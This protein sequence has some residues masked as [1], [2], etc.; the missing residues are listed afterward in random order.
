M[1]SRPYERQQTVAIVGVGLIGVNRTGPAPAGLAERVIGIGRRQATLR[2]ARRVEAVT[3]TTI[4]LAKG[5]AEAELIVVCTPVG[6][7]ADHVRGGQA[8][9]GRAL[10]TDA[11]STKEAIVDALDGPCRAVAAFWAAIRW[12]AARRTGQVTP[13]PT[14]STAA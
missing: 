8:L 13:A 3:N 2:A 1:G 12:P 4:D 7:I 10:I 14:C 11:G 6:Q 9:P 5:V